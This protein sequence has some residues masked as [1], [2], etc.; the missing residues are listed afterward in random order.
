MI[1]GLTAPDSGRIEFD[2]EVWFDSTAKI[3][4]P[5][6]RRRAGLVFQD[7][8]LFPKM[9]VGQNV[10]YGLARDAGDA[11][12]DSLLEMFGLTSL[13]DRL[14]PALSGGQQQRVAL[15]RA[16]AAKPLVVLLDEPLSALDP[17]LRHSLQEALVA[18]RR[19]A[20][21]P[22]FLVSHDCAEIFRLATKIFRIEN[23]RVAASGTPQE[24]FGSHADRLRSTGQVLDRQKQGAISVITIAVGEE[25]SRI[26]LSHEEAAGLS[27]GD[28]VSVSVK[29]F[30]PDVRKLKL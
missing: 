22:T 14:P 17:A 16:L 3:N 12:A 21:V 6:Q 15:A 13:R 9:T 2:T 23:G 18:A 28:M 5:P 11:F 26:A 27:V 7:Y 29:A 19:A 20:P 10:R 4:I 24:I 8:A 30:N 25:I 1:A